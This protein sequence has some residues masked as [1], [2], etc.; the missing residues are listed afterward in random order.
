MRV[1]EEINILE[2]YRISP[3]ELFVLK[4]LILAKEGD[5]KYLQKLLTLNV[6]DFRENLVSL[7]NKDIL[8]KSYK[9]PNK[10]EQ[11]VIEE[12][13]INKNVIKN[14]HKSS[15]EMGEELFMAYPPFVTIGEV[16]YGLRNVAKKFNSL[17]DFYY[18]YA[19]SINFDAVKHAE[20]MNLLEWANKNSNF[21]NF[22]ILEFV[23]SH[24][25]IEIQLIKDGHGSNI[26]FNTITSI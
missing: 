2:K 7:K 17:E 26:N 16:T 4:T 22:S 3:D 20:I 9:I 18:F 1:D 11:L 24:K 10:G 14:Y 13:A 23:I 5:A 25:W 21:L 8:L 6:I 12:V 15:F 19:K